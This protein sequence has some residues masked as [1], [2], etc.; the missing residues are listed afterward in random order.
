[1]VNRLVGKYA[2][3]HTDFHLIICNSNRSLKGRK[4]L[5][6]ELFPADAF[7]RILIHFDISDDVLHSRIK[8]SQ[9]STNIFRGS[10]TNFEELLVRQHE[11]SLMEEMV[12]PTDKEADH[13][14]VIRDDNDINLVMQSIIHI[15]QT[16]L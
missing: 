3:E 10:I 13:L 6:E 1:M 2:K 16:S 14:L 7:V 5:L 12:D 8:H 4:Y 11:E 15:A 9:R